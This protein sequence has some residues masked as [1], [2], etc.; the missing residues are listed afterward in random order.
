ML[1]LSLHNNPIHHCL[2]LMPNTKLSKSCQSNYSLQRSAS[3][4]PIHRLCLHWQSLL[5]IL[6]IRRFTTS[7]QSTTRLRQPN[8]IIII[9]LSYIS[10]PFHSLRSFPYLFV[11]ITFVQ[12]LSKSVYPAYST[13]TLGLCAPPNKLLLIIRITSSV[14]FKTFSIPRLSPC[15]RLSPPRE[16]P[17]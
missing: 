6:P 2:L 9:I 16:I 5:D 13:K 4:F 11:A 17:E 1:I 10:D 14:D 7:P 3:K 8:R 15:P 12:S